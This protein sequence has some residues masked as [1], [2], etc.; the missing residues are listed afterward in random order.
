MYPFDD[1]F[2]AAPSVPLAGT[3]MGDSRHTSR[4]PSDASYLSGNDPSASGAMPRI[5]PGGLSRIN[6]S[7]AIRKLNL[8]GS[9]LYNR[10]SSMGHRSQQ[11]LL[12]ARRKDVPSP[13]AAQPWHLS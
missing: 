6:A 8:D 2:S 9:S 5:K 4:A 1:G 11:A 12:P 10:R 13:V 3:Q 7:G